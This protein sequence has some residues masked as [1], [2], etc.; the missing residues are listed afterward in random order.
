MHTDQ[1]PPGASSRAVHSPLLTSV[2]SRVHAPRQPRPCKW[3][4]SST[5]SR[6]APLEPIRKE[7]RYHVAESSVDLSHTNFH[8]HPIFVINS[9]LITSLLWPRCATTQLITKCS[10]VRRNF[11][12]TNY[13]VRHAKISSNCIRF[14]AATPMQAMAYSSSAAA[15]RSPNMALAVKLCS[16]SINYLIYTPASLLK[17]AS[18]VSQKKR[19]CGGRCQYGAVMVTGVDYLAVKCNVLASVRT[20]N[21]PD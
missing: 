2:A 16:L 18:T 17:L 19:C 21:Q 8:L 13:I 1:K 7:A 3:A 14:C 10:Q 11:P 6:K 20:E 5:L 9:R 15:H 12:R 4:Q